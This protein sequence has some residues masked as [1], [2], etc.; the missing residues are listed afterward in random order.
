MHIWENLELLLL[1]TQ[2]FLPAIYV[3]AAQ[4]YALKWELT[5]NTHDCPVCDAAA[6]YGFEQLKPIIF[7][8][9]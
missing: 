8:I 3:Y 6:S 1:D 9:I 7:F 2:P 4:I 5:V